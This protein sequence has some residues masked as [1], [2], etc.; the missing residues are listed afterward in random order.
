MTPARRGRFARTLDIPCP[1]VQ[2]AFL[3]VAREQRRVC[4]PIDGIGASCA[5]KGDE[6]WFDQVWINEIATEKKCGNDTQ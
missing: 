1:S 2:K 4:T 6:A 3:I 5:C